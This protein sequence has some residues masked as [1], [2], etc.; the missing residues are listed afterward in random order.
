MRY[1]K[2]NAVGSCCTESIGCRQQDAYAACGVTLLV[3]RG[4]Q[5]E[6]G[7]HATH[8]CCTVSESI[9]AVGREVEY[10]GCEYRVYVL[11]DV[12]TADEQ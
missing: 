9:A 3:G 1:G 7:I 2:G 10:A 12:C 6:L 4:V 8:I 11:T 5:R